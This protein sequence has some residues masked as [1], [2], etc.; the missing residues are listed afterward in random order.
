MGQPV[1]HFEIIGGDPAKLRDYYGELFGWEYAVGDTAS[2]AV[3]APGNYGF[4]DGNTTGGING[5]V[6]G[7]EG[8]AGRV[9][10]YVGVDN[11]EAALQKA[12]SLGGKRRMGPE[13]T[14]GTLVVGQFTDPEGHL[15]GVAGPE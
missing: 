4:V 15:I 3:S 8:Y 14:P 7:G 2:E 12:E 11:V 10:F 13:G 1:V 6:G 5:G 9:L